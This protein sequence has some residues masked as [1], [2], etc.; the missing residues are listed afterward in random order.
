MLLWCLCLMF[1]LNFYALSFYQGIMMTLP[2]V[3]S[4]LSKGLAASVLLLS[5]STQAQATSPCNI[6]MNYDIDMTPTK[7]T[8]TQQG[9]ESY[10]IDNQRLFINNEQ[11]RLTAQQQ[12]SLNSYAQAMR[13]QVPQVVTL[14]ND[15]VVLVSGA[16]NESLTPLLGPQSQ[17][18][19]DKL[20]QSLADK[21]KT[22]A[23]KNGDSY[24][25]GGDRAQGNETLEQALTNEVQQLIQNA[26]GTVMLSMGGQIMMME[27]DSFD[28]K[29][30]AFGA[31]MQKEAQQIE[32]RVKTNAQQLK[33][34][35]N[36]MCAQLPELKQLQQ[37]LWQQ[38]PELAQV[39]VPLK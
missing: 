26:M 21:V 29:M 11:I 6:D 13:K 5:I 30:L 10:R 24:H 20:S 39:P 27:G 22:I 4:H 31:K 34:Q 28:Q 9:K 23:V 19:I 1:W 8:F 33:Q 35:A 18:Q 16:L 2:S 14:A 12:A 3:L 32:T 36:A 17:P 7:L 15:A 38:V 37:Q 25:L